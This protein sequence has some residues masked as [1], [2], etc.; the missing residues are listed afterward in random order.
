M[1]FGSA[2]IANTLPKNSKKSWEALLLY[3][4]TW[5]DRHSS[6][7]SL[8]Y[9]FSKDGRFNSE[10]E[11]Q[12]TLKAFQKSP[13]LRCKFP[14]RDLF[15][16]NLY[17]NL[18]VTR[19][20][21]PDLQEFIKKTIPRSIYLV[22][23]SYY[24]N[25]PA[26]MFGHTF[27][28]LRSE[29]S[30]S[31]YNDL[32][33]EFSADPTTLN[34]V[35]YAYL[36]LTGGFQGNFRLL[37]YYAKIQEYNDFESRALWEY[38][39]KLDKA[40]RD[41]FVRMIYEVLPQDIQYYYLDD[42]CSFIILQ[43][44]SAALGHTDITDSFFLFSAP[45]DTVKSVCNADLCTNTPVFRASVRHKFERAYSDLSF[46]EK[47]LF[48]K[49]L[50]D[51]G[52]SEEF[53]KKDKKSQSRVYDTLLEFIRYDEGIVG[54]AEPTKRL[55]LFRSALINRAK[56]GIISKR[57]K[58]VEKNKSPTE[59]ARSSRIG[60]HYIGGDH[61]SS[62]LRLNLM[63]GLHKFSDSIAGYPLGMQFR[64]LDFDFL[65]EE[66]K[67]DLERLRWFETVSVNRPLGWTMSVTTARRYLYGYKNHPNQFET[68]AL[69]GG[70]ISWTEGKWMTFLM[71][72][73]GFSYLDSNSFFAT[74][75]INSGFYYYPTGQLTLG[76]ETLRL[77]SIGRASSRQIVEI[78]ISYDID[79]KWGAIAQFKL[80]GNKRVTTIGIQHYF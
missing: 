50:T 23:A 32:A 24:I 67:F 27:L 58:L 42:N 62:Y 10:K 31:A 47:N 16:R 75:S 33:L 70:G 79:S 80:I 46:E 44:I 48:E 65:V 72:N 43:I 21:C 53:N 37:P 69:G 4:D 74:G 15:I 3:K 66:K 77:Y 30:L 45:A 8:T 73:G 36:G 20:S 29:K 59:G 63:G 71:L 17:P 13:E 5:G 52:Y 22:F 25:N 38:E 19:V 7:D 26:S 60:A 51:D 54:P 9:F 56:L 41:F 55:Q 34:P 78:P 35:G 28:R 14:A 57:K 61:R 11:W 49:I 6:I 1:L 76:L 64:L 39:L 40:Q 2:L 68:L 18:L 12:A